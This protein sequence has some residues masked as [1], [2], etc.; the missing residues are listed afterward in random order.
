MCSLCKPNEGRNSV[1]LAVA[2]VG[3]LLILVVVTSL[4]MWPRVILRVKRVGVISGPHAGRVGKLACNHMETD[5]LNNALRA[6]GTMHSPLQPHSAFELFSRAQ[7]AKSTNKTNAEILRAWDSA[8]SRTKREY[9]DATQQEHDQY[10]QKHAKH[11]HMERVLEKLY[12]VELAK[13]DEHTRTIVFVQGV[14]LRLR[15]MNL[16]EAY[17]K[18]VTKI[19]IT[20]QVTSFDIKIGLR[21]A[22]SCA[23][24]FCFTVCPNLLGTERYLS[25]PTTATDHAVPGSH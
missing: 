21:F 2:G 3:G 16:Q 12:A 18:R 17:Q 11:Q 6:A 1:F 15:S 25:L 13:D 7:Q 24:L 23:L 9:E 14:E 8:K 20:V 19:K 22:N 5:E 10:D 4:G